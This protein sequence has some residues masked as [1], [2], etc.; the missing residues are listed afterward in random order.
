MTDVEENGHTR[1][2]EE[3]LRL[4]QE[5]S[6]QSPQEYDVLLLPTSQQCLPRPR[7]E[8][9]LAVGSSETSVNILPAHTASYSTQM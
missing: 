1:E 5:T 9:R 7:Q 4:Q 8:P 6:E 3:L 2:N